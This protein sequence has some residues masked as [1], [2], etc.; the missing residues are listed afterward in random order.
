MHSSTDWRNT[1]PTPKYPPL[2]PETKKIVDEVIEG[3]HRERKY[4]WA[5]RNGI[6]MPIVIIGGI[7]ELGC[8]VALLLAAFCGY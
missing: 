1:Y 4:S 5:E 7:I 6:P 2:D 8:V 3:L